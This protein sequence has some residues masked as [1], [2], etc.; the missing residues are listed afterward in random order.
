MKDDKQASIELKQISFVNFTVALQTLTAHNI[1]AVLSHKNKRL[2]L[3]T[4]GGTKN[5]P[6]INYLVAVK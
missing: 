5:P 4:H 6:G 2:P 3:K 1:L